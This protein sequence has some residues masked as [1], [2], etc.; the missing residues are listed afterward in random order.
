[1]T[2]DNRILKRKIYFIIVYNIVRY[3]SKGFFVIISNIFG[4]IKKS[5]SNH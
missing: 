1:M 3:V 4:T 2:I 5:R